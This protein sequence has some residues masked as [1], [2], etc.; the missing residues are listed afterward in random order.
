MGL[1][2]AEGRPSQR[3]AVLPS[4]DRRARAEPD[5]NPPGGG[6][7][8]AA[9]SGRIYEVV[10]LFGGGQVQFA[11]NVLNLPWS[12]YHPFTPRLGFWW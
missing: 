12:E 8:I 3:E 5:M 6:G 2:G 11:A 7:L 10:M 9:P 4:G 1:L